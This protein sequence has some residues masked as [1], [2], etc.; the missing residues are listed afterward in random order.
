MRRRRVHG[1]TAR[2]VTNAQVPKRGVSDAGVGKPF[3]AEGRKPLSDPIASLGVG[4]SQQWCG[5]EIRWLQT[6]ENEPGW[7]WSG[8]SFP[9]PTHG[10]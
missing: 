5:K 9:F 4:V 2:R 6:E 3:L 1:G 7:C 8:D 10:L